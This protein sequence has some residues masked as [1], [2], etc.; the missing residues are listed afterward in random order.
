ME[1]QRA[2]PLLLEEVWDG[3]GGAGGVLGGG[4][5][6]EVLAGGGGGGGVEDFAGGVEEG[7]DL[8]GAEEEVDFGG[9]LAAELTLVMTFRPVDDAIKLVREIELAEPLLLAVKAP[10]AETGVLET[11]PDVALAE[12]DAPQ[13]TTEPPGPR[14]GLQTPSSPES[15]SKSS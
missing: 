8:G 13:G 6:V 10:V 7:V 4:G 2:E 3:V 9:L 14:T 11:A 12:F 5:G 1:A 15:S